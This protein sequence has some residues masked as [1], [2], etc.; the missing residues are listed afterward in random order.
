MQLELNED[1][2]IEMKRFYIAQYDKAVRELDHIKNVLNKLGAD[3]SSLQATPKP[4]SHTRFL[5]HASMIS[6]EQIEAHSER[7][8]G[9]R[10]RKSLW[11]NFIL[12]LLKELDR[13]LSYTQIIN[14]AM[15]RF[16]LP[17]SKTKNV[18]QAITNSAFR[19]RVI[20]H[21][22]D[23]YGL[24]GKKERFLCLID[25]FDNGELSDDMKNKLV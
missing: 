17:D 9:T 14:E 22:I 19:L 12:N 15:S 10:G 3:T 11:G 16:N 2:I 20:N 6:P 18:K 1:E 5:K 4:E 25:W 21:K 8:K 24:P 23:T 13:P 7:K